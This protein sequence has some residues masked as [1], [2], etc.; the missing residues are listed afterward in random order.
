LNQAYDVIVKLF[1]VSNSDLNNTKGVWS[2][3]FK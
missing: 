3:C 1:I 2:I